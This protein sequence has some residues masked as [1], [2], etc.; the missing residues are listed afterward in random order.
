ML[1][2]LISIRDK[3]TGYFSFCLLFS[4]QNINLSWQYCFVLITRIV[5]M[6]GVGGYQVVVKL[7]ENI[8]YCEPE[9]DQV[10]VESPV[11]ADNSSI[12]FRVGCELITIDLSLG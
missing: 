12:T 10:R 3:V 7:N 6:S 5:E 8:C 1:H 2:P 11:A 9:L 4:K